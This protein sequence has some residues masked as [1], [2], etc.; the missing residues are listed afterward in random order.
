MLHNLMTS[1]S[2]KQ[3]KKYG[4]A[5]LA[6]REKHGG[7]PQV[8]NQSHMNQLLLLAG[9]TIDES[10]LRNTIRN[11]LKESPQSAGVI[12][13]D[14]SGDEPLFLGLKTDGGFDIPKG[15]LDPGDSGDHFAAARREVEEET[16]LTSLDFSWGMDHFDTPKTRCW[17]AQSTQE[18]K[19]R[20]NPKTGEREHK[21]FVWLNFDDMRNNCHDHLKSAIDWANDISLGAKQ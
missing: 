20:P 3:K 19:I 14:N 10:F 18:P 16:S 13:I 9:V 8:I 11:I 1:P 4:I 6:L 7:T 5:L 12:I 15:R 17:I 21:G 2:E